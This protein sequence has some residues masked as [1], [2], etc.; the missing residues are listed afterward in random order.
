LSDNVT[1]NLLLENTVE[2][3]VKNLVRETIKEL[4]ACE[5]ETC[6]LNACAIALNS[7]GPKYVTTKMGAALTEIDS[8][9]VNNRTSIVIE[10]T[11][12]VKQVMANPHH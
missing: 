2:Y 5:C 7:L 9:S 8:T 1:N 11:K 3:T 12:A 4:G 6:F 10:V